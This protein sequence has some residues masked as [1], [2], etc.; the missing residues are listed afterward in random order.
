[1]PSFLRLPPH[2]RGPRGRRAEP[3]RSLTLRM[4]VQA[5]SVTVHKADLGAT[6]ADADADGGGGGLAEADSGLSGAV[7]SMPSTAR[8]AAGRTAWPPPAEDDPLRALGLLGAE[9]ESS[10]LLDVRRGR[11][12]A[13]AG[14]AGALRV[15]QPALAGGLPSPRI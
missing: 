7:S 5:G 1:M 2:A 8:S 3:T 13:A 11:D 15:P 4:D 6:P 12:G 14:G 9:Q 10:S